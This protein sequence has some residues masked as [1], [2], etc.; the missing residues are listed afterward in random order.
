MEFFKGMPHE[1]EMLYY[2]HECAVIYELINF[3]DDNTCDIKLKLFHPFNRHRA[4][5]EHIK[6]NDIN[7]TVLDYMS[8][9]AYCD[10]EDCNKLYAFEIVDFFKKD[11]DEV[12]NMIPQRFYLYERFISEL[13]NKTIDKIN[14]T[15]DL[16]DLE[17]VYNVF[18]FTS[19]CY[20]N[21]FK[22]APRCKKHTEL[23]NLIHLNHNKIRTLFL[24]KV[25]S[26]KGVK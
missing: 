18:C 1:M 16:D 21:G 25:K 22:D 23:I 7:N 11:I 9:Q 6:I 12:N 8:L 26:M 5:L 13:Y 15:N 3:Y 20:L 14:E 2:D 10:T 19:D 4:I 17:K 24:E